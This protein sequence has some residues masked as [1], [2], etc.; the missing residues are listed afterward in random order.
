MA[1]DRT[2][3]CLKMSNGLFLEPS[4]AMLD[5]GS[6]MKNRMRYLRQKAG[7]TLEEVAEAAG[8]SNQMIG[9]LERG[10]R[11]LTTNW[12]E[13][14]APV[15]GVSPADLMELPRT[16]PVV[17]Y[18]GAGAEIYTIDDHQKGAGMDL[19]SAPPQGATGTMVAL[20]V[21]GDSMSPAYEDGDVIYYDEIVI[22]D[23]THLIGKRVIVR[24]SDGRT[25]I[26]KLRRN[27]DGN[28]WLHSHNADP[29]VSPQIEWCAPV[30]WVKQD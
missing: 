19:I 8:T 12:M 23:F 5:Y 22:G 21:R 16:V 7:L 28:Y 27:S 13:R 18:V 15:L 11:N 30:L 14:I 25:F 1:A 29:I 9:M 2:T 24:L 3:I 20:V 26:K 4:N 17:G 6:A 10:Q